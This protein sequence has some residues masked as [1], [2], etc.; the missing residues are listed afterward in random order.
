[1]V[2]LIT[3]FS[4]LEVASVI[5]QYLNVVDA[6]ETTRTSSEFYKAIPRNSAFGVSVWRQYLTDVRYITNRLVFETGK[7][8]AESDQVSRSNYKLI[9]CVL[10][11]KNGF[12]KTSKLRGLC[13]SGK[14]VHPI[15]PRRGKWKGIVRL[16]QFALKRASLENEEN[17]SGNVKHVSPVVLFASR[18]AGRAGKQ[19]VFATQV[20]KLVSESSSKHVADLV[21]TL[22]SDGNVAGLAQLLRLLPADMLEQCLNA[23]TLS[24]RTAVGDNLLHLATTKGTAVAD[25]ECLLQFAS[26]QAMLNERNLG[27]RA[28]LHACARAEI[29]DLLVQHGADRHL[30]DSK[31]NAPQ[32]PPIF[33]TI[34]N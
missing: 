25:I 26:I 24:F 33:Q 10:S 18:V 21:L 9:L 19:E 2:S 1:M 4:S 30:P 8:L 31:G 23:E 32:R 12:M 28:P 22:V 20:R 13:A 7:F 16:D 17:D 3:M 29:F 27:G 14:L 15:L 11:Q 5:F 6:L 34:L